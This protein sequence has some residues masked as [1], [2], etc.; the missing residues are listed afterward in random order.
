MLGNLH[1]FAGIETG[2]WGF[3]DF[4]LRAL[5]SDASMPST[6]GGLTLFRGKSYYLESILGVPT[7]NPKP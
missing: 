5:M 6:I 3:G 2:A 7:L 4:G 1:V